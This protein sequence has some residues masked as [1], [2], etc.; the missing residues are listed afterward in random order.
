MNDLGKI[1]FDLAVNMNKAMR[2]SYQIQHDFEEKLRLE[3]EIEQQ[4]RETNARM[5]VK[6]D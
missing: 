5:G 3:R 1:M 6:H 2:D 4:D